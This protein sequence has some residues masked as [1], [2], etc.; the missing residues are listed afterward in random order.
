MVEKPITYIQPTTEDSCHNLWST[1]VITAKPF[2]EEFIQQLEKDAEY[3]LKPGSPSTFNKTNIWELPDLPDS[4][5]EIEKK[6]VE[7]TDKYYRPLTEMPLPPLFCSKGYFREIKQDSIY[8]ISPHK[9]A[10]TLGVG[11]IYLTVPE[12]N[13]GNLVML[14]PR[15]G[16]QWHNQ[17]TPF[18]RIAVERGL[19]VI[20]PGY[21]THFVE[22]TDYNCARFDYRL[23][24]I[25]NIHWKHSDFIKE[26]AKNEELLYN[27][28]SI[29]L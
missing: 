3:L 6:F 9:H 25:S 8:R 14:D 13:A 15:G 16:V 7:L 23:A 27:M 29:E 20:H 4:F 24:I 2:T 28:G 17:F 12:R 19:M 5:R 26:L 18:K 21:V 11:I 10:Q 22:P 1:P